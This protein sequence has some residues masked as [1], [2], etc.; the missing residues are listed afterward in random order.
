MAD[1]AR[2][3]RLDAGQLSAGI[4]FLVLGLAYG[5]AATIGAGRALFFEDLAPL[6]V[7]PATK[8]FLQG[9]V[10]LVLI[11]LGIYALSFP[12]VG[13]RVRIDT[14]GLHVTLRFGRAFS[15]PWTAVG[16][17]G[18]VPKPPFPSHSLVL[19]P[20]EDAAPDIHRAAHKIWS[21]KHRGWVLQALDPAADLIA[22]LEAFAPCPRR[23]VPRKR[24]VRGR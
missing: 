14:E 16:S 19:W 18:L 1:S 23:D 3:H 2:T 9:L 7:R 15:I 13:G 22:D 11:P 10:G 21:K 20:S 17:W 24:G 12:T 5:P 8:L 6:A 4:F